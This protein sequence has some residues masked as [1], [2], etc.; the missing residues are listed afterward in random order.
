MPCTRERCAHG[1]IHCLIIKRGKYRI[2]NTGEQDEQHDDH[3]EHG[4]LI[5]QKFMKLP[6]EQLAVVGMAQRYIQRLCGFTHAD[7][8]L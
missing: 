4:K 3:A 8:S 5:S 7:P 2:E 6:V 1:Q